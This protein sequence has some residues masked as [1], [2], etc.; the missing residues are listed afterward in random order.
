V[1]EPAM[2][3]FAAANQVKHDLQGPGL[4]QARNTCSNNSKQSDRKRLCVWSEQ[5]T[6]SQ[7]LVRCVLP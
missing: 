5:P 6:Y 2:Q 1:L 7:R 4:Q 3:R